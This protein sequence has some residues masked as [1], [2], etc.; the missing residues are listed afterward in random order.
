MS[1]KWLQDDIVIIFYSV[2]E[3]EPVAFGKVLERNKKTK[4]TNVQITSSDSEIYQVDRYY[5]IPDNL[6]ALF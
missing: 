3:L 1:K 2:D 6:L 4:K 5:A